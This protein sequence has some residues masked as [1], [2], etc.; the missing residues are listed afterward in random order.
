[1]SKQNDHT[2]LDLTDAALKS[3]VQS[4]HRVG[5]VLRF[6]QLALPQFPTQFDEYQATALKVGDFVDV[7]SD[8]GKYQHAQVAKK[9]EMGQLIL[10][11]IHIDPSGTPAWDGFVVPHTTKPSPIG[12]ISYI[13]YLHVWSK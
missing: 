10:G 1:M 7:L 2:G 6:E 13:S 9:N 5:Y 8:S 11:L 12:A 3:L 4:A